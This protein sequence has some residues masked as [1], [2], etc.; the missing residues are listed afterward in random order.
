ML[1]YFHPDPCKNNPISLEIVQMDWVEPTHLE[2]FPPSP[3][4][5]HQVVG[6]SAYQAQRR[7]TWAQVVELDAAGGGR[8]NPP[9]WEGS[10]KPGEVRKIIDSIVPFS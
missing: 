3:N 10:Q 9:F 5:N 8:V 1:V 7:E 4:F 6:Y 2:V